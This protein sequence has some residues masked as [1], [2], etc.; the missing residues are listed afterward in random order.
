MKTWV[1]TVN[2]EYSDYYAFIPVDESFI[3]FN[4]KRPINNVEKKPN[5]EY[6]NVILLSEVQNGTYQPA[7]KMDLAF[8]KGTTNAEVIGLSA[9]GNTLLLYI[10]DNKNSG[11]IYTSERTAEGKFG[12]P[13]LLD[14]NINSPQRR[15][16]SFYK[17]RRRCHLFCQQSSGRDR[18]Y[19]F[20]CLV[21][22]P[23]RVFGA[24][25]KT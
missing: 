16:C 22:K 11:N 21:A 3:I 8:P 17:C 6:P 23:H 14:K 12:Q 9:N 18:W 20:V 25:H 15:N 10:K 13:V 24:Y 19:R 4:S 2:S 7:K 1:K 5:G